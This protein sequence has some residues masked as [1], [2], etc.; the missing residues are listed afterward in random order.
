MTALLLL[1]PSTP[2]LFQGQEFAASSSFFYFADHNPG[3]AKLVERGRR[4]FL[5]QF[6]TAASAES[7]LIV[8]NPESEE[9]FRRSKLNFSEREQHAEIYQ[10]HRDLLKL[11]REDPPIRDARA[12][13]FDGA[14]LGPE[15]FVLRF[16]GK[17]GE[18]RLLLVNF[19]RDLHLD[20]A[21]EPLL[22]PVEGCIWDAKWSSE[23][24]CYGGC[25][26]PALDTEENWWI[27]GH[28]AVLLAPARACEVQYGK[29]D[30]THQSGEDTR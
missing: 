28:A 12:G 10:L 7:Q 9:T 26:T 8:Q 19:G 13:S 24:T 17:N 23:S 22:A 4:Q 3:L 2:M 1:G 18:D 29:V 30:S 14:V 27:P 6:K 5:M 15:V 25:G 16:F 21:P 11:R 20:P